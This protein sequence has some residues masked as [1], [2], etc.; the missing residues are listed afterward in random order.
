MTKG[1]YLNSWYNWSIENWGTKWDLHEISDYGLE[2]VEK[3]I[4]E[5]KGD[6]ELQ[7]SYYFNTAWSPCC[8]VV[9]AMS[10][11][12]PELEFEHL[13]EECG[14]CYAGIDTYQEG[15]CVESLEAENSYSGYKAFLHEHAGREYYKCAECG[16]LLEE[17]DFEEEQCCP[18]CNSKRIYDYDGETLVELKDEN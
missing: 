13:Y 8:P 3:A 16:E 14:C 12:F 5:N 11:Q 1:D 7:V 2:D 17:W 9:A 6:D 10:E 18:E 4:A 15:E